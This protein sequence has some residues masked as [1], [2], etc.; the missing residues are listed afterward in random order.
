MDKL[1]KAGLKL[2]Y[3]ILYP[4]VPYWYRITMFFTK[5]KKYP[6]KK[7]KTTKEILEALNWG[8]TWTA[9][10]LKGT[11]DMMYHPTRIQRNSFLGRSIGDCDDHAIY[12]CASLLK[13][14]LASKVWLSFYQYEKL[15]GTVGGH[16]VCVYRD[17]YGEYYWADYNL[18]E[19]IPDTFA[20]VGLLG[21]RKRR[22]ILGAA[23]IEVL[24]LKKDDTPVFGEITKMKL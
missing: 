13:S 5:D 11:F 12:W 17:W 3:L 24:R 20:W 23:K 10:P 4:L 19:S 22:K 21:K 6:V 1:K 16:V 8:K 18:P 7:S 9:D 15:D 2:F 14:K